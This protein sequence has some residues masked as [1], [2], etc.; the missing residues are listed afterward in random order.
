MDLSLKISILQ[1]VS[2]NF[3]TYKLGSLW[4]VLFGKNG[5]FIEITTISLK[6]FG[7]FKDFP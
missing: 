4:G 1:H 7:I 5:S 2:H 6:L 3:N